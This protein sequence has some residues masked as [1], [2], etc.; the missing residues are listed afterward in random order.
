MKYLK[1]LL[2]LS[3][4]FLVHF[5]AS[6]QS[7]AENTPPTSSKATFNKVKPFSSSNN[8]VADEGRNQ[9]AML[10]QKDIS[11][12]TKSLLKTSLPEQRPPVYAACIYRKVNPVQQVCK[13]A[14]FRKE[15]DGRQ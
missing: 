15:P 14:F 9:I 10:S 7:I 8:M 13:D 4:L 3:A 6:A 2:S 1:I 5:S 11:Q 12:P